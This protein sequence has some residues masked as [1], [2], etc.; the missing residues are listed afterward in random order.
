[1][2]R[3]LKDDIIK[4]NLRISNSIV[5]KFKT[6]KIINKE[7]NPDMMLKKRLSKSD[8]K[9]LIV[10]LSRIRRNENF[11]RSAK[12]LKNLQSLDNRN[13]LQ[14]FVQLISKKSTLR[15]FTLFEFITESFLSAWNL[16]GN[17]HIKSLS[18]RVSFFFLN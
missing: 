15:R 12:V 17:L 7:L 4:H 13:Q 1:M 11:S 9:K 10:S 5:R 16:L 8:E 3:Y 2:Q 14:C 18:Q 6:D